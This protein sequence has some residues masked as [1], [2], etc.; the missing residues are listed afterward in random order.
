MARYFGETYDY[1]S[2]QIVTFINK[3]AYLLKTSILFDTKTNNLM[4]CP[5]FKNFSDKNKIN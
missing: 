3:K 2:S 1:I 5:I 4:N